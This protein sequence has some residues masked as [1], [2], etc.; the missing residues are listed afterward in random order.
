MKN[1]NGVRHNQIILN[2][3]HELVR[4]DKVIITTFKTNFFIQLVVIL[5]LKGNDN[6]KFVIG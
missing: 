5:G 2:S 1:I 6:E 3:C 4:D